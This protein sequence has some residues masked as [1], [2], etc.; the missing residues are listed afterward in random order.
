M[1]QQV[2]GV[3]ARA[4][5]E[6]VRIETITVPDP[7]PGEAHPVPMRRIK[8]C[9]LPY[10]LTHNKKNKQSKRTTHTRTKNKKNNQTIQTK[11]TGTQQS[12]RS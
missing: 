3:V 6:P 12:H 2:Q 4:K 11:S 5:G 7:G 9:T 8:R 1:A 10:L